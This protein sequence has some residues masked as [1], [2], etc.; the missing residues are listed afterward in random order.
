MLNTINQAMADLTDNDLGIKIKSGNE[1]AFRELYDRYHAQMYYIAKQYVKR[2]TLA[3]DAVQETFIKFWKKRETI[4]NSKSVSGLLFVMLK[5][6]LINILR[7]RKNDIVAITQ[8][9]E[10]LLQSSTKTDDDVLY[11]EY[12]NILER[13]LGKLSDRKREVFEL[14]TIKGHTNSEVADLLHIDIKTVKTHYYLGSKFI[15]AY[16]KTHAGLLLL[17][18]FIS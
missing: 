12:H 5:N 3:E 6:H 10:F 14:R 8:E 2:T 4:D 17:F 15:R 11:E 13:G 1:A 9:N 18:L 16:L 7:V